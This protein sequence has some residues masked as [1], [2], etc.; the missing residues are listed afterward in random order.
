MS[1]CKASAHIATRGTKCHARSFESSVLTDAGKQ[2][3]IFDTHAR[4]N[5]RHK[6]GVERGSERGS[7]A[8]TLRR[9]SVA[10]R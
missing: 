1:L 4:W 10:A 3:A 5:L 9:E 8:A 6:G 2:Y 7:V